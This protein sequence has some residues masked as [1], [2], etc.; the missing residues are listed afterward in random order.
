MPPTVACELPQRDRNRCKFGGR[1][2]GHP[3]V[4]V[5]P[6]LRRLSRFYDL[7]MTVG[8]GVPVAVAMWFENRE[9]NR[10]MLGKYGGDVAR[11]VDWLLK[12]A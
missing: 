5:G 6:S 2:H 4:Y 12:R 11:V 9:L 8:C 3:R 7:F 10:F 1:R